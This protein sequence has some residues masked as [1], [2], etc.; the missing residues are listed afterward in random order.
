MALASPLRA[1]LNIKPLTERVPSP[2]TGIIIFPTV[3]FLIRTVQN[4]L[5]ILTVNF[6]QCYCKYNYRKSNVALTGR[7][8]LD[9]YK[10]RKKRDKVNICSRRLRVYSLVK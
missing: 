1:A 8:R 5:P 10:K 3:S 7:R 9:N 6:E 2:C 4:L